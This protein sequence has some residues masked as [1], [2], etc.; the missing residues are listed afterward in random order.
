MA[1]RSVCG[2]IHPQHSSRLRAFEGIG[3]KKAAMAVEILARDLNVPISDLSGGDVAV[4]IHVRRVFT[5]TRIATRDDP[6][7]I[8]N[9]A[10]R[11]HPVRPGALDI[12][13]WIIGRTWCRP[14]NPVCSQCPI[15]WV[16]PTA[17]AVSPDRDWKP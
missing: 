12:P 8:V 7:E 1:G 4:D 11:G 2:Q 13:A 15:S 9:A 3:Q 5:R 14:R 6:R 17:P 16:C 10:R